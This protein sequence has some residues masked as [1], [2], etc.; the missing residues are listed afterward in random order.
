MS[1]R[2]ISTRKCQDATDRPV[3]PARARSQRN[4]A[5]QGAHQSSMHQLRTPSGK[6]RRAVEARQFAPKTQSAMVLLSIYYRDLCQLIP[7]RHESLC[8]L[9]S[10]WPLPASTSRCPLLVP[11]NPIG[12][13]VIA[14]TTISG[15]SRGV[16]RFS[17]CARADR[18]NAFDT[19]ILPHILISELSGASEVSTSTC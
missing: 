4:N 9:H 19:S 6:W 2:S 3:V 10:G 11:T 16:A 15:V 5:L 18:A 7:F 17:G 8:H 13:T 14:T 12:I 1:I